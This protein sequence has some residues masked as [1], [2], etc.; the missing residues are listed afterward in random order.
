MDPEDIKKFVDE[1]KNNPN[2]I[3]GCI[4]KFINKSGQKSLDEQLNTFEE[5]MKKL[6][7]SKMSYAEMRA[8]YG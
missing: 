3:F 5:D 7:E 4:K 8:R 1:A 2:S 6:R